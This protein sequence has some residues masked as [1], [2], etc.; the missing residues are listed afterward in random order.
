MSEKLVVIYVTSE[1]RAKI[2]SLK[3]ELTYQ[4][5]LDNLIENSE[6]KIPPSQET[7]S[8]PKKGVTRQ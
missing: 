5:F 4:R 2:K 1:F 8:L 6:G 3:R 7:T